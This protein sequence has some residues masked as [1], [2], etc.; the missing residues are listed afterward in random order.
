M[1]GHYEEFR[2]DEAERTPTI[3]IK[4]SDSYGRM[5]NLNTE[6]PT[7]EE[8]YMGVAKVFARRS[9]CK[10]KQVGCIIVKDNHIVAEGYNGTPSGWSN[11]CEDEHGDTKPCV[12]HAEANAISKLAKHSIGADG[13]TMYCT[14][15]PCY[16]CSKQIADCGITTVIYKEKYRKAEGINYLKKRGLTVKH[17]G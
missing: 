16:D 17:Y 9:S 8:T 1:S 3:I 5:S 11:K 15:S 4:I 6:R 14:L 10:K 13:A 7:L 2:G 12:S